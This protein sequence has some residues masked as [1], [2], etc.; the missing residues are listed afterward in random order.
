MAQQQFHPRPP[1]SP[2]LDAERIEVPVPLPQPEGSKPPVLQ[3]ILPFF[4]VVAMVGVIVLMVSM[5]GSL[6]PFMLMMPLMMLVGV[7]GLMGGTG[8]TNSDLNADRRNYFLAAREARTLVHRRGEA[9]FKA[10]EASFPQPARLAPLIGV[11]APDAPSMWTVRAAN[12]GGFVTRAGTP[13]QKSFRPYLAARLGR[14]TVELEPQL[15]AP[16]LPVVEQIE[17]VTLGG[18]RKFMRVQRFVA[19]FPIGYYLGRAPFHS[20]DG[21]ADRTL[22]LARAMVASLAFNHSPDELEFALI[23][24]DPD[25]TNW[26]SF[27]WLPHVNNPSRMTTDGPARRIYRSMADFA[28]DLPESM[29]QRPEFQA[30][31]GAD[32]G[33]VEREYPHLVVIIDLP[34][35]QVRLPEIFG[36]N[37]IDGVTLLVVRAGANELPASEEGALR[38]DAAGQISTVAEP[39]LVKADTMGAAEFDVFARAMGRYRSGRELFLPSLT[40]PAPRSAGRTPYLKALGINDLESLDVLQFWSRTAGEVDRKIPLADLLD[41]STMLPTGKIAELNF[42]ESSIGGSGP[43]GSMQGKTGSGKSYLLQP[44]VLSLAARYSPDQFVCIL[45]DFKGGSTFMGFERL[46]HVLANITNLEKDADILVRAETVIAGELLKRQE[47]LDEYKVPDILAYHKLQAKNPGKYPPLPDLFVIID[48]FGEFIALNPEFK[49][50]FSSITRRGRSLGMHLMLGSQVI[51]QLQ[52]GDIGTELSFGISLHS[53]SAEGS[54]M[55]LKSNAATQLKV[56]EGHAYLRR[57]VG[58]ESLVPIQGFPVSD[59]YIPAETQVADI[60]IAGSTIDDSP[61]AG[62]SLVAF[63]SISPVGP[64]IDGEIEVID[65]PSVVDPEEYPEVRHAL[66]DKL[67]QTQLIQPRQ[68]WQP[69]LTTP[70][71]FDGAQFPVAEERALRIRIGDLDD[72]A[73]HRRIPYTI[74]PEGAGAHVRVIGNRGTGKSTTL[75]TMIASAAQTYRPDLVQFYLIDFG[76]KLQEVEH[77]PNVGAR[78]SGADDELIDRIVAE[79]KRVVEIRRSEFENRRV[80]SFSAYAASKNIEPVN[81]DP[82]GEMFLVV[83]G[84][85][86]LINSRQEGMAGQIAERRMTALIEIAKAGG[87]RGVHLIVAGEYEATNP[88]FYT[89]FG[90]YILH[91]TDPAALTMIL[92]QDVRG[93]LKTVPAAQPGRALEPTTGLH[94]RIFVPQLD[95]IEP[96]LGSEPAEYDPEADYSAGIRALGKHLATEYVERAPEITPVPEMLPLEKI[97]PAYQGTRA[98]GAARALPLGAAVDDLSLVMLPTDD[99][100][101]V[102]HLLVVGDPQSGR[103][104]VVRS[105]LRGLMAQYRPDEAQVY[106]FDPAYSMINESHALAAVGLL[107]SYQNQAARI[108]TETRNIASIIASREPDLETVTPEQIRAGAWYQGPKIFVVMDPVTT[109]TSGSYQASATDP[110]NEAIERQR[111]FGRSLGLHVIATDQANQYMSRRHTSAFYK[112]ITSA[113]SDVLLLSG[114]TTE[115]VSGSMSAGNQIKFARRRQGLGQLWSPSTGIHPVV[116]TGWTPPFEDPAQNS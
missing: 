43:H 20:L 23:T 69:T 104:T 30:T 38:I 90:L 68:L 57:D 107:A 7:V 5:S 78:A 64:V 51:S 71:S 40:D 25:G 85:N 65:M 53:D 80:A 42:S 2:K 9:M 46:P 109:L 99:P 19:E 79:F 16:E 116:Q 4:M 113:N 111:D 41:E 92:P 35:S 56:G 29:T 110:L 8:S 50:L 33:G 34:A 59:P 47:F 73:N 114:S 24:D 37:G 12:P 55:V 62:R 44:T 94:A 89:E 70:I 95:P 100:Q 61:A 75:Q 58:D 98:A 54:R 102:P 28:A 1:N 101:S 6:N 77:F 32:N 36:V 82:Y 83:D 49:K 11:D 67:A 60:G 17:P 87:S 18:F 105:L 27:K 84:I 106:L 88:R 52:I 21:P 115:T 31:T 48:E 13:E 97:W 26:S 76:S 14:G 74:R 93:A 96:I 103:S 81:G 22:P 91:S 86:E 45:M 66:L 3:R 72:P 108:E 15:V 63:R 10:Q 112:A 39:A